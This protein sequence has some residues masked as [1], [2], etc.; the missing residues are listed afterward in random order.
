MLERAVRAARVGNTSFT[1]ETEVRVAGPDGLVASAETVYVLVDATTLRKT[2]V[3]P[4][5]R[6]AME[7]GAPDVEVDHAGYR[8]NASPRRSSAAE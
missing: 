2:P 7:A 3:P 5:L 1:V 6:G 4:D 8:A